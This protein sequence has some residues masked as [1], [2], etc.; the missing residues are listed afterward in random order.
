VGFK[1]DKIGAVYQQKEAEW[2]TLN[3]FLV[4]DPY[5]ADN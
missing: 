3:L 1:R 5:R 2:D 4:A